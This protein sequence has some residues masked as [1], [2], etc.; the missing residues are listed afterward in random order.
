MDER[1]EG[2]IIER[3]IPRDKYTYNPYKRHF[4]EVT[5]TGQVNT[6]TAEL[7]PH[8]KEIKRDI[9]DIKKTL[10]S[11][12][13]TPPQAP[14]PPPIERNVNLHDTHTSKPDS[15]H[16]GV[17]E[18]NWTSSAVQY[19]VIGTALLVSLL[20]MYKKATATSEKKPHQFP[21]ML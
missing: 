1:E 15:T 19:V 10:H 21:D 5:P 18:Y 14:P 9:Q 2:E 3:Y 17:G 4:M 20:S 6:T 11:S 8:I 13:P 16:A 12:P 7:K